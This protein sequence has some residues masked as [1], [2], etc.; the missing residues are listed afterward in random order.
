VCHC[1]ARIGSS[2]IPVVKIAP[3][4]PKLIIEHGKT[5]V[6]IMSKRVLKKDPGVPSKNWNEYYPS[7]TLGTTLLWS[8]A[9]GGGIGCRPSSLLKQK[10]HEFISCP[11]MAAALRG[12]ATAMMA[13]RGGQAGLKMGGGI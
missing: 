9:G 13:A 6:S 5:S 11:E 7:S 2:A 10:I 4:Q 1:E 12:G 8:A 3:Q